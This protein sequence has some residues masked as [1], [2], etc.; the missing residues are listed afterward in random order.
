MEV[1]RGLWNSDEAEMRAWLAG[2]DDAELDARPAGG[3]PGDRRT[4]RQYLLHIVTHAFQ[5]QADAAT[6]LTLAGQSPGNI[7][8]LDFV[9]Q[10]DAGAGSGG[11]AG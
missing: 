9:D 10:H 8:Y 11:L 5:Q 7:E 6:L 1:L 4:L 3:R 2:M